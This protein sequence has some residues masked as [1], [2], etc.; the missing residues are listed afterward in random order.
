M[1]AALRPALLAVSGRF[2]LIGRKPGLLSAW[3][4]GLIG[5]LLAGL[6]VGTMGAAAAE[7]LQEPNPLLD[8]SAPQAIQGDLQIEVLVNQERVRP[9]Q[10]ITYTLRYTN[11][12]AIAVSNV[13]IQS[14][15]SSGQT[16]N[17]GYQSAP[18]IPL[19]QFS[20]S[21]NPTQKIYTLQW[22]L[23][24]LPAGAVGQ[25]SFQVQVFADPEPSINTAMILL[26][27][28][29]EISG[30]GVSGSSDQ[31]V[32]VVVGPLLRLTKQ[33][34]AASILPGRT[35]YYTI[36]VENVNRAD[37]I[38]ATE[39]RV[40]ENLPNRTYFL[41]ATPPY[42]YDDLQRLITW[43]HPGPLIPGAALVFTFTVQVDPTTDS[44]Y[45]IQNGKSRYTARSAEIL[46]SAVQGSVAT[47]TTVEPTLRKTA[48]ARRKVGNT[49]AVYPSEEV[50]YTV[51]V[52]NPLG[53]PLSGVV[54]SDTVPGQPEPFVYLRPTAGSPTPLVLDGGRTLLWTVDLAPWG[55]TT[56]GFVVQVP[57]QTFIPNNTTYKNYTNA[58]SASH[59]EAYFSPESGLAPVRVEAPVTM[60]KV[61]S[62]S[63]GRVGETVF[64]TITLTNNGPFLVSDIT[65]TDTLE[66]GFEYL[67]MTYG[68]QPEP[69]T[70]PNPIVWKGLQVPPN[71]GQTQLAFAARID[72][73]WLQTYYNNL[74]AF[75]P[76]VYIPS[77]TRLAPVK[78]LPDIGLTKTAIPTTTFVF[79]PIQYTIEVSNQSP[80]PWTMD[81]VKDYLP[82][83]FTQIGGA[84]SNVVTF[85]LAPPYTLEPGQ[86]WQGIF[87]AAATSVSC[88]ALPK[89]FPNLA[90]NVQAH[91]IAPAEVTAVNA[92]NLAPVTIVP[93]I[94]VDLVPERRALQRGDVFTYTLYLENV[95]PV[96]ANNSTINLTLPA[97]I[98]YLATVSGPTPVQSGSTLTWSGITLPPGSTMQVIMTLRVMP[99]ATTGTKT[100]T[101]NATASG[102]CFGKLGSGG[103]NLGTGSVN[104]IVDV[105]KLEKTALQ[106]RLAPLSL[107]NFDIT[108]KNNDAYP[109]VIPLVTDT[110]PTGF[111]YYAMLIGPAPEVQGNLLIWRNLT[112]NPGATLRL[113]VRMQTGPLYGDY[114]N[115]VAAYSPETKISPATSEVV[116]VRP[117]FALLKANGDP[118]VPPGSLVP[119]TITLVNLSQTV[120]TNLVI[121][122]TLPVGLVFYGMRPGYPA[123]VT[124]Q[125]D[126]RQPVWNV[127][128]LNA[129]CGVGGCQLKLAFNVLVSPWLSPGVYW[130]TIL[131][132]SPSGSVPG[133]IATAPLTVT[134]GTLNFLPLM[135]K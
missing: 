54:V 59:P 124:L 48:A 50:T 117:L 72:G 100:P 33:V 49:P 85:S 106:T 17:G 87:Q 90:G 71:G 99:T 24:L 41:S 43:Q 5:L 113:R 26:G 73:V 61:V 84:G 103:R 91:F 14:T 46:L 9:S 58:L 53:I 16:Y 28:A 29:V 20:Y 110:M 34:S 108:L 81:E 39:L 23:P 55:M 75:S 45:S 19:E 120:Y 78:V 133:P 77:R 102:V 109:F 47:T 122:D 107:V 25:I 4:A 52:I 123:P 129:N 95:S 66:G 116:Q 12:L 57:R 15:V 40:Q 3:L 115:S 83:G 128:Q 111:Q 89:S 27:N 51:S 134:T 119:Y 35:L 64:Y 67:F 80:D 135:K 70:L 79:Q 86:T 11:T 125:L 118:Y 31:V 21:Y 8:A 68:P 37:A 127:A 44:G 98:E 18:D 13:R 22:L 36:T 69:A 30:D 112:I 62:P 38:P 104:V 105:I 32:P 92:T 126:R 76:D 56:F 101:F 65:L 114:T 131:G 132:Y 74:N 130:N 10:V 97:G 63:Q 60:N 96:S 82:T 1:K 93:N 6:L 2:G 88:S 121:T 94:Q 42:D 7:P